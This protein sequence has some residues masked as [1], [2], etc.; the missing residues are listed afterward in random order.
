MLQF[1]SAA[2]EVADD[3]TRPRPQGEEEVQDIQIMIRSG[4]NPLQ[5]RELRVNIPKRYTNKHNKI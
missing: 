5:V 2:S 3:I 1:E 4:S